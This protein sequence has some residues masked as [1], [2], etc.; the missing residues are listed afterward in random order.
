MRIPFPS[1]LNLRSLK[2]T[3]YKINLPDKWL[4]GLPCIYPP[5]HLQP[6]TTLISS[7]TNSWYHSLNGI[8][9]PH[10][11]FDW[12][13][14]AWVP[15]SITNHLHSSSHG[16]PFFFP[17]FQLVRGSND[18][19]SFLNTPLLGPPLCVDCQF[20]GYPKAFVSPSTPL[21]WKKNNWILT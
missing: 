12:E 17:I 9:I 3:N 6:T 13:E 20:Y 18:M 21:K 11:L 2:S 1:M 4:W 19:H 5:Y 8:I 15:C 16:I 7:L 10:P 14:P